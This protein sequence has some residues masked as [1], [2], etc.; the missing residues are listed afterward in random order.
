[1]DTG[2]DF[3]GR[4]RIFP[5]TPGVHSYLEEM[6]VRFVLT[7]AIHD[8]FAGVPGYTPVFQ[9]SIYHV[10]RLSGG[11]RVRMRSMRIAYGDMVPSTCW[12]AA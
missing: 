2:V 6:N 9:D 4:S 5:I 8:G 11:S 1:M 3:E 7:S 12:F 10:Y